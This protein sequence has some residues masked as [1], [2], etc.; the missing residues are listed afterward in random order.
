MNG[1]T[2]VVRAGPP[3]LP[4]AATVAPWRSVRRTYGSVAP[5]TASTA[6]AQRSDSERPVALRRDLVARHDP[7]RAEPAQVA[8]L[9]GLAGRRPHLVAALGEDRH[10]R[11]ADAARRARDEDRPVAGAQPAVLQRDH[12]HR[13]RE[14]GRADGHRL[15][16][17]QPGGHGTTQSAGTRWYVL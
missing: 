7:G 5:P 1:K 11:A 16:R 6:P 14:A 4:D 15:A 12:A 13:G 3:A 2:V 9:V 8:L 17:R 10:G